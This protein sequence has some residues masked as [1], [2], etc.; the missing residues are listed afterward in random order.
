MV[1]HDVVVGCAPQGV[2]PL[3]PQLQRVQ[4]LPRLQ[5]VQGV[6]DA[7]GSSGRKNDVSF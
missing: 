3:L 2:V 1:Q 7:A 6:G 5:D 4:Q